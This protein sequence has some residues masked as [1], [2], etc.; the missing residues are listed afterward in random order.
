MLLGACGRR[1]E[2]EPPPKGV[3]NVRVA[4]S[5]GRRSVEIA[6][7]GPFEVRLL[8]ETESPRT[9]AS[10]RHLA[11]QEVRRK[12][13][14]VIAGNI[15]RTPCTV[16]FASQGTPVEVDGRLYRGS[17]QV[18]SSPEGLRV[19]NVVDAEGYLRGV[20]PRE[21][22]PQWPPAALEAQAIAARSYALAEM[23]DEGAGGPAL[24]DTTASQVYG[25][26]DAE[27]PR[28]DAAVA[29]TA[30]LVLRHGPRLLKAYYH[31]CCGG[32]TTD[33]LDALSDP[34]SPLDGT[35]CG[36]CRDAPYY[37]WS[38][39]IS[40]RDLSKRLGL[41]PIGELRPAIGLEGRVEKVTVFL[42][43]GGERVLAGPAFRRRLGTWR[44][45]GRTRGL[46][47]TRFNVRRDGDEFLF[48]GRGFG[49]GVGLCQWGA[50][51]MAKLGKTCPE[52]LEHYYPGVKIRR[53][54]E[55]EEDRAGE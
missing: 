17:V 13:V 15:V 35:E 26:L 9:I 45:G 34:V 51:G 8:G 7:R 38:F 37:E 10:G 53:A 21:V 46:L 20:L 32:R 1:V 11:A 27:D 25:G 47:S 44:S 49:H 2:I 23:N 40:R 43:N 14:D 29:A 19:V 52:I 36:Y 28:T 41:G 4:L 5:T 30:G 22:Y 42:A 55:P 39:R 18:A 50:R 16:E 33:A 24:R 54:Y 31:A 6:V 3:P 12:G 48:H